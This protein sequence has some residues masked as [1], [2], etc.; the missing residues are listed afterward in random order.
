MRRKSNG[1]LI[2]ILFRYLL[3]LFLQKLIRGGESIKNYFYSFPKKRKVFIKVC[4]PNWRVAHEWGDFHFA[5]GLKKYFEKRGYCT[6]IQA[7]NEWEKSG[8]KNDI[9]IMIRGLND[10][11]PKPHMWSILWIISHPD[12]VQ[13]SEIKSYN[14]VFAASIIYSKKMN[15]ILPSKIHVLNQCTDL[16]LF[17]PIKNKK[18]N[19]QLLFVGNT[20][21]IFRKV[22]KDLLPTKHKLIVFGWGW[23]SFL[24]KDLIGGNYIPNKKL[25][26]YYNKTKILLND[27][28][29]DMKENGFISNRIYDGVASGAIM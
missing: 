12:D 20:R 26:E 15:E 18:R 27:H 14:Y 7:K 4:V 29:D 10:Y 24:K 1:M 17:Y 23:Q 28:W 6:I 8:K 21:K 3:P 5:I 22:I 9:E 25:N 16:D 13:I 11:S 2:K 19:Y